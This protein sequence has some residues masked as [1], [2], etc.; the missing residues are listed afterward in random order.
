MAIFNGAP[1][2][3]QIIPNNTNATVTSSATQI[4]NTTSYTAVG[5]TVYSF[6]VG[7]TLRDITIVNTGTV[8]CFIGTSAVTAATGVPLRAGEQLTI[9]GSHVQAESGATSWNLYAIT[10]SST[11]TIEASLAT[12]VAVA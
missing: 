5:G 6:P 12:Q 8:T 11:T 4:Y 1:P 7:A 2:S 10:A 3:M 9:Q